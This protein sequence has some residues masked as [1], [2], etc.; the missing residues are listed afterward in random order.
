MALYQ[1]EE[2]VDELAEMLADD[3]D[4]SN[5][6][7]TGIP[8]HIEMLKVLEDVRQKHAAMQDT[9]DNLPET[10]VKKM[11]DFLEKRCEDA[12]QLS[13]DAFMSMQKE[14]EQRLEQK[15]EDVIT[16]AMHGVNV[17]KQ[18]KPLKKRHCVGAG[19]MGSILIILVGIGIV[20]LKV[21]TALSHS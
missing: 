15:L 6:R 10:M 3:G 8:P 14:G 5:M 20:C 11:Y 13:R 18:V 16:K 4:E 7:P 9:V 21:S 2:L 1:N 17:N 19:G 12:G